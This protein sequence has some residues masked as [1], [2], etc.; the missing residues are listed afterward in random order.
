MFSNALY[1]PRPVLKL[2]LVNVQLNNIDDSCVNLIREEKIFV[3]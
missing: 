2:A 3:S 1:S